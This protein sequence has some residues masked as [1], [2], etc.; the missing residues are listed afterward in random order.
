[1]EAP[2]R[3][4]NAP[5]RAPARYLVIIDGGGATLARLFLD[6]REPAGEVDASTEEVT[7]MMRG[8]TPQHGALEPHWDRALQGHS[9]GERAAARVFTLDL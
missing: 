8:L 9:E 1:M 4:G 7:L 2:G 3:H 5:G 6:S